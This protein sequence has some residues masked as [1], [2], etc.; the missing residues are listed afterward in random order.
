VEPTEDVIAAQSRLTSANLPTAVEAGVN[1]CYAIEDKVWVD[2][3]GGELWE[4]Y[5]VLADVD[6]G[7][8]SG[9]TNLQH[10]GDWY[11]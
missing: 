2:G 11:R 4:I 6:A 7:A 5:T 9:A 1:Y 3:P 8:D 10:A